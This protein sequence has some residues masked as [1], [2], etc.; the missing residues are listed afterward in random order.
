[1]TAELRD[2]LD[3]AIAVLQP[4]HCLNPTENKLSASRDAA[5]E[6]QEEE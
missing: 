5:L 1:M 3:A 4:G 2:R 6:A